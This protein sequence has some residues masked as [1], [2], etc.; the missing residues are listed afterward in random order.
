MECYDKVELESE[1]D[2]RS[3]SGPVEEVMGAILKQLQSRECGHAQSQ[4]IR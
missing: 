1:K 4:P 2:R 3:D